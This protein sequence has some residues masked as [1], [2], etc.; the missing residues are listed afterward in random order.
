MNL[1]ISIQRSKKSAWHIL[2]I[3]VVRHER[4]IIYRMDERSEH[5]KEKVERLRRAMYSR[6]LSEKLK[7]RERRELSQTESIVGS[8]FV[9]PEKGAPG[10]TIAPHGISIMRNALWILLAAAILFFF[11]S[12]GYF[13]WYF[14]LGGGNIAASPENI[15]ISISSFFFSSFPFSPTQA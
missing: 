6:L 3:K 8:D 13:A 12:A 9:S 4:D 7:S 2:E 15:S 11:A 14:L 1:K 5:E 10:S